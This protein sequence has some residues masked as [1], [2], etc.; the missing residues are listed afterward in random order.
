MA[1]SVFQLVNVDTT[2]VVLKVVAED[3]LTIAIHPYISGEYD[4]ITVTRGEDHILTIVYKDGHTFAFNWGASGRTLI[5]D[6][7]ERLQYE[8][9]CFI[10]EKGILLDLNTDTVQKACIYYNS[11]YNKWQLIVNDSGYYWSQTA[12]S[13]EDMQK[14]AKRFISVKGWT[15]QTAATGIKMWNAVGPFKLTTPKCCAAAAKKTTTRRASVAKAKAK[16]DAAEAK[17]TA[18]RKTTPKA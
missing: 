6:A 16:T 13:A 11:N 2:Q 5:S 7:L 8:V 18:R 14:E 15:E 10:E 9:C 4:Y 17:A 1:S 3:N 12:Q